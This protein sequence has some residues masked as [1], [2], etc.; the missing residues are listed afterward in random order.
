MSTNWKKNFLATSRP[1]QEPKKTKK[2]PTPCQQ[3]NLTSFLVS[4]SSISSHF[5][6]ILFEHQPYSRFPLLSSYFTQSCLHSCSS[7]LKRLEGFSE[8]SSTFAIW[9]RLLLAD[10]DISDSL[11]Y[12]WINV[13]P[14]LCHSVYFCFVWRL[15]MFVLC[16]GVTLPLSSSRILPCRGNP[17]RSRWRPSFLSGSGIL[18]F[19]WLQKQFIYLFWKWPIFGRWKNADPLD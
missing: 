7:H 9:I 18:P 10:G 2:G 15:G 4:P 11:V 16:V 14:F 6:Q 1:H 5:P 3:P 8:F 19:L 13:A 17:D 12:R